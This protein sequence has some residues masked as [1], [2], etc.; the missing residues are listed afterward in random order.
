MR[1]LFFFVVFFTSL[2][3]VKSQDLIIKKTGDEVKAKILEIG[4]AEIKYKRY[5]FQ[6]GPIYT[7][8]KSEVVL[9]RYENGINEVISTTTTPTTPTPT[10]VVP[11]YVA[12]TTPVE[13]TSSKIE[14][15]YGSYS[16]NG[17]YVSKSRVL[18]ILKT[19]NDSEINRLLKK[20]R[21][22]KTT[23]TVIATALG[24]PLMVV[25]TLTLLR[26]IMID[27]SGVTDP[28]AGGIMAVGGV[29]AGT[30]ILL[31][32]TNIG[33]QVKSKSMVDKAIAIYNQKYA[34]K[35]SF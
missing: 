13:K 6:D 33:F 24:V 8:S 26:G 19:V 32:F 4:S 1:K 18:N 10:E 30:G 27:N 7:I 20:A 3:A 25:G 34:D 11:Q 21:N 22:K 14:Y 16:Q 35:G 31:Q 5:D 9:I 15:K 12:P 2:I 29:M 17:R 28:D 23:G